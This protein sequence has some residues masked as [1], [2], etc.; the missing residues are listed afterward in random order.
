MILVNA[1]DNHFSI[2]QL[3]KLYNIP[4]KTLR[5]YDEIDLFKPTKVNKQNGYRYYSIEQFK[6]L[7]TINY[8]KVLGVPLK[9][10][11]AHINNRD[12]NDFIETLKKHLEI[13][14]KKIQE[15]EMIKNGFKERLKEIETF[16][17][18]NEVGVPIIKTIHDR[19]VFQI[20]EKIN[21][22]YDLELAVRKLKQKV[23]SIA[24]FTIGKV[25]LTI[26]NCQIRNVGLYEYHSIF[27]LLE[28]MEE[29]VIPK[30]KITVFPR[31]DYACIYLRGGHPKIPDYYEILL[32]YIENH[33][34][35]INGEI[36]IRTVIDQFISNDESKFITEIQIPIC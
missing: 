17:D 18:I 24:P 6:L 10:I 12:I 21:S 14:E 34:Y 29:K 30:D 23:P 22:L 27:F 20:Q 31:G 4:I 8:L 15:L 11:K 33:N 1:M 32:Q 2:G 36:I 25:G 3:S 16:K 9:E 13:T 28:K 35:K 5:Y 26:S 7:D 19:R